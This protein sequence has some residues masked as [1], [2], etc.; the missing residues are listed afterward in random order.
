MKGLRRLGL[1]L[2]LLTSYPTS[3]SAEESNE[4]RGK[5]LYDE[6]MAA[7]TAKT[8]DV[9]C[10]KFQESYKTSGIAGALLN[11]ADC[12]ETRGR[13]ATALGLW[14]DGSAKVIR[15][16]ARHK[17]VEQRIG[18]ITPRVPHVRVQ[19][20]SPEIAG[21]HLSLDGIS[22][23]PAKPVPVDPGI[24]HTLVAA[25]DGYVDE[26]AHVKLDFGETRELRFFET[27]KRSAGAAPLAPK[28][29]PRAPSPAPKSS[30][31]GL[32]TAGIVTGTIGLVGL[33]TFG[34]TS[35]AVLGICKGHLGQCPSSERSTVNAL[36]IV[37]GVSLGLGIAGVGV[38]TV[39]L[40][41]GSTGHADEAPKATASLY[42]QPGGLGVAGSF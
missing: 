26:T 19:I 14:N 36:G 10:A 13:V 6:G 40:V 3:A 9:A 32:V 22:V 42:V 35:G 5:R 21:A 29:T 7:M 38:G 41:V 17:F 18:A 15:D 33:A 2:V 31:K 23:D 39:L 28:E 12:E 30:K 8:Y 20:V 24:D 11:W 16:P 37:N 4:E 25:A 27:P 1:G 34:A